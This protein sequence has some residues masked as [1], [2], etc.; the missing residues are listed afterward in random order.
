MHA[1]KGKITKNCISYVVEIEKLLDDGAASVK[2]MTERNNVLQK[3]AY[4]D[5]LDML[6]CIKKSKSQVEGRRLRK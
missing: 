6:D 1:S 5:N 3:V 4:I 2:I